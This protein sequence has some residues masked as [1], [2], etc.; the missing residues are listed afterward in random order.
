MA[1]DRH[2]VPGDFYRICDMT[3]FK[4]RA[5]RT[6]KMWSNTIRRIQSWEPRQPQDFV[7][8]VADYQNVPE[9]RDRQIDRFVGILGTTL[10]AKANAATTTLV[11]ASNARFNATDNLEI[12]LDTG[13]IFIT[14]CLAAFGDG[15]TITI[16]TPLPYSA[17]T[18]NVVYDVTEQTV[19]T[20]SSL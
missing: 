17:S 10:I 16:T 11:L 20:A 2:Y 5:G 15:L 12:M 18:G 19:V 1:D 4:T 13:V 3:G 6:Q 8:G 9:P 7:R 14:K